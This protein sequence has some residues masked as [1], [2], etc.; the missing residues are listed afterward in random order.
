MIWIDIADTG[1][2]IS[3]ADMAKIFDPF[4]TTK[5][6]GKG[7]GLGLHLVR[8]LVEAHDGRT[9]VMSREGKGTTFRVML[10]VNNVLENA[11]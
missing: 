9:T 7:S 6:H 11:I 2:G 5:P 10:P 4:F 1:P 3:Q 8:L